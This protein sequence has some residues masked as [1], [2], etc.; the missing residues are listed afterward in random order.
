MG[1]MDLDLQAR[2]DPTTDSMIVGPGR[3]L[4]RLLTAF[5]S[6][7]VWGRLYEQG[8]SAELLAN[9]VRV[10]SAEWDLAERILSPLGPVTLHPTSS[11][12]TDPG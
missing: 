2:Y 3:P 9:A 7:E 10:P 1:Y 5:A 6:L 12:V 8:L 11:T 4:G